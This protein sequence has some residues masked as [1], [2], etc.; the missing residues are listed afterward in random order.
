MIFTLVSNKQASD[1]FFLGFYLVF[2][3]VSVVRFQWK[4]HSASCLVRSMHC[5][6]YDT[7]VVEVFTMFVCVYVFKINYWL[8]VKTNRIQNINC[9]V[10]ILIYTYIC[11]YK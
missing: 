10:Y 9:I 3:L 11:I 8:I 5:K 4:E 1:R 7:Q 2:K 6:L